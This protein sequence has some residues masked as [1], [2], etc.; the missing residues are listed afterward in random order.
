MKSSNSSTSFSAFARRWP[1]RS[2]VRARRSPPTAVKRRWRCKE[3]LCP[4]ASFTESLP[5]VRARSRLTTRLRAELGCAVAEQRRCVS[6]AAGHYG[7][8]WPI[9]PNAFVEQVKV[10]LAAPLPRPH[11]V[12]HRGNAPAERWDSHHR[13]RAL[14]GQLGVAACPAS[15]RLGNPLGVDNSPQYPKVNIGHGRGLITG[16]GFSSRGEI[17]HGQ[18]NGS[19]QYSGDV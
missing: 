19:S 14:A 17:S 11:P 9:V 5:A 10:P 12:T 13:D 15:G 4:Q 18:F 1:A 6:E 3:R 7:A 8:S 2:R 16:Q